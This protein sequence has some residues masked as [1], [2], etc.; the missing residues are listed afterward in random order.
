MCVHT[1]F[2]QYWTSMEIIKR[3]II[4]VK[5]NVNKTRSYQGTKVGLSANLLNLLNICEGSLGEKKN[6]ISR[7]IFRNTL[8]L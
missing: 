3:D 7:S 6:M 1:S 2:T 5:T 8:N 4:E